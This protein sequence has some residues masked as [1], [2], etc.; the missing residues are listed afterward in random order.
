MGLEDIILKHQDTFA[1]HLDIK[2]SYSDI[3]DKINAFDWLDLQSANSEIEYQNICFDVFNRF[4]FKYKKAHE[5]IIKKAFINLFQKSIE[6]I[7]ESIT[8]VSQSYNIPEIKEGFRNPTI[9]KFYYIEYWANKKNIAVNFNEKDYEK[10]AIFNL[11]TIILSILSDKLK[12]YNE[13][14]SSKQKR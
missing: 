1:L 7:K 11:D 4:N 9:E 14:E 13:Y 8:A 12:M 2:I 5:L 3:I 6:H 10:R